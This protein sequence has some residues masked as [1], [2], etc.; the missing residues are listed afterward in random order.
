VDLHCDYAGAAIKSF[1]STPMHGRL[2]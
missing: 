2:R 1:R